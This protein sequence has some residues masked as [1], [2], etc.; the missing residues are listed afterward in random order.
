MIFGKKHNDDPFASMA[1]EAAA[2]PRGDTDLIKKGQKYRFI[3][4]MMRWN[5][6]VGIIAIVLLVW[7]L[8]VVT[9]IQP[10]PPPATE[11]S[12]EGKPLAMSTVRSW[13]AEEPSP[14]PGGSI[15]SWDGFTDVPFSATDDSSTESENTEKPTYTVERHHLTVEDGQKALFKVDVE[16]AVDKQAG[17]QVLGAPSL[18]PMVAQGTGFQ[19]DSPWPGMSAAANVPDAVSTSVISWQ[20]AFT[21]GNGN[22]LRQ[23]VSDPDTKH[24]YQA[25]SGIESATAEVTDGAYFTTIKDGDEVETDKLLLRVELAVKWAANAESGDQLDSSLPVLTYDLL[26]TGAKSGSPKVVAWGGPGSGQTLK[27]YGN[28]IAVNDSNDSTQPSQQPSTGPDDS[29]PQEPG[30]APADDGSGEADTEKDVPGQG[31]SDDEP[32]GQAG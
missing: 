6:I 20:K 15:L 25:L 28:A 7:S 13:L 3:R 4:G 12:S 10:S 23:V 8:F 14:V 11:L 5:F 2:L 19:A 9:D 27:P 17:P 18:M 29:A 21:S 1:E 22:E 26:V 32:T 31:P 16:I 30:E 24:T